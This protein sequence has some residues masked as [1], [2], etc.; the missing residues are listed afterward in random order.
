MLAACAALATIAFPATAAAEPRG[1][2][3]S[4]SLAGCHQAGDGTVCNLE[5]AFETIDGADRYTARVSTPAGGVED[6]G[7]VGSG[8]ASL[9]V[10][11]AGVG[12]YVVTISAW[13]NGA[14]DS[15]IARDSSR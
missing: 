9:P 4:A 10:T 12:R 5:V 8:F 1:L 14:A 3:V 7:Q 13:G 6:F 15:N 2:A 11:Y